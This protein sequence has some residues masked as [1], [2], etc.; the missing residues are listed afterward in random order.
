MTR[1]APVSEEVL[2]R[3]LGPDAGLLGRAGQLGMFGD[4]RRSRAHTHA[5]CDGLCEA[6]PAALVGRS[7][8]HCTLK[9]S[10]ALHTGA[11]TASAAKGLTGQPPA[12]PEAS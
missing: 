5:M 2:H 12:S 10:A 4:V 11:V 9:A 7:T 3:V 8:L 1:Q 6:L